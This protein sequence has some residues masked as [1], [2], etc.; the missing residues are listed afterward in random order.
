MDAWLLLPTIEKLGDVVVFMFLVAFVAFVIG[1]FFKWI[2]PTSGGV[3]KEGFFFNF[4]KPKKGKK[5]PTEDKDVKV[6]GNVSSLT[7]SNPALMNDIRFII[8]KTYQLGKSIE[9]IEDIQIIRSQMN[10]SQSKVDLI[11]SMLLKEYQE[12]ISKKQSEGVPNLDQSYKVFE[13]FIKRIEKMD[14]LDVLKRMYKENGLT[15]ILEE[16]YE[17][18]YCRDHIKTILDGLY[19][20]MHTFLPSNINPTIVE[21]CD[22]LKRNENTIYKYLKEALIEARNIA[23]KSEEDISKLRKAFEKD[24]LENFNIKEGA[25]C[26]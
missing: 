21:V 10:F 2:Q 11:T 9:K 5:T 15:A 4:S 22:I 20:A 7:Q 17:D 13:A 23:E 18:G 8:L 26:W 25:V 24:L 14:M 19:R 3:S 1:A 12:I 16:N 6:G